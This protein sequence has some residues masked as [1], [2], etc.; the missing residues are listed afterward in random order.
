MARKIT[1][2]QGV[3]ESQLCCGCGVCEFAQPNEITMVDDLQVGRR[4]VVRPDADTSLALSCCPGVELGHPADPP[5]GADAGLLDGWGPVLE[6]WEGHATDEEIRFSGSSG[7]VAT[8]LGL[9]GIVDGEASGVIHIRQRDD[10]P[11]LNESVMSSDRDGLLG[12]SG[13][14]YAPAS[15]CD[16]L[17]RAVEAPQPVVFIGKP[18]DVAGAQRAQEHIP[19]LQGK[20]AITVAIFCAGAPSTAGSIEMLH[21][22]GIDEPTEVSEIR[23]RGNGWPGDAVVR[24]SHG[25]ADYSMSYAESWGRILQKHRPWR[26]R[27]CIDHTGEFA[28]IAV[29]DPW[30]REIVPGEPGSSL[31]VVRTERGR[32]FLAAAMRSGSVELRRVSPHLLP[33]SQPNLLS[34]RGSVWGR[35]AVSRVLGLPTPRYMNMPTFRHWVRELTLKKQVSSLG[36]TAKRVITRRL[37]RR[38]PVQ[39]IDEQL[40]RPPTTDNS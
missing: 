27:L 1:T 30:Y 26:C 5:E 33:D 39:P 2:I 38:L 11:L 13:S 31:V 23:Y 28:D 21:A 4:P 35:L 19:D 12:G 32:E 16:A 18:C 14:R 6:V 9:H 24:T 20:L 25:T 37:H 29:G 22:L 3:A 36:G 10:V 8:A 40:L 34:T 7:G 17:G 15:P